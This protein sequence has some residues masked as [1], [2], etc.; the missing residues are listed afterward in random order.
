MIITIL[1]CFQTRPRQQ[2]VYGE[3]CWVVFLGDRI[4]LYF[5]IAIFI[6]IKAYYVQSLHKWETI[7]SLQTLAKPDC[8]RSFPSLKIFN[9]ELNI[10]TQFVTYF[11]MVFISVHYFSWI[12][13]LCSSQ[14][15][16]NVRLSLVSTTNGICAIFLQT[17][18]YIFIFPKSKTTLYIVKPLWL[19]R[20]WKC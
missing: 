7:S 10:C 18:K 14:M 8:D 11:P 15:C 5:Y 6:L 1:C 2:G 4:L 20:R 13:K 16:Q 19:G 9:K 3:L 12:E 17:R